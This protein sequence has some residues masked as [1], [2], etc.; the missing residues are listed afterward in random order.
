MAKIPTADSIQRVL[1]DGRSAIVREDVSNVGIGMMRIGDALGDAASTVNQFNE[2][3]KRKTDEY[4]LEK[5]R[6]NFAIARSKLDQAASED[7]D[8]RSIEE[9]YYQGNLDALNSAASGIDDPELRNA[10]MLEGERGVEDNR[11]R[12]REYAKA[13][14]HDAERASIESQ[15]KEL[16]ELGLTGEN[17]NEAASQVDRLVSAAVANEHF[18]EQEA[19]KVGYAFRT[20]LAEA[21]LKMIADPEERLRVLKEP[22]VSNLPTDVRAALEREARDEVLNGRAQRMVDEFIRKDMTIDQVLEK[23]REI[24]NPDLRKAVES[25]YD[26]EQARAE[27]NRRLEQDV[28]Y[29]E[30]SLIIENDGTYEEIPTAV[31]SALTPAMRDNLRN[32]QLNRVKPRERSDRGAYLRLL[33]LTRKAEFSNNWDAVRQEWNEL[34]GQLNDSDFKTFSKVFADGVM[35]EEFKPLFTAQNTLTRLMKDMPEEEQ[36]RLR[37]ELTSWYNGVYANTQKVPSDAI[38]TEHLDN[39][40]TE[41]H[42][43]DWPLYTAPR[44]IYQMD[45]EQATNALAIAQAQS[46]ESA[47]LIKEI[48]EAMGKR[49]TAKDVLSRFNLIKTRRE[50]SANA[51]Q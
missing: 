4:Q 26:Y 37:D 46:E 51:A 30:A 24:S 47:Q 5:A 23:T 45:E 33:E 3:T 32:I 21:R 25:R 28:L 9:R 41:Y 38:V 17:F 49:A 1:P 27:S 19:E 34:S 29:N 11:S 35:P 6:T 44:A 13:K 8:Y 36:A 14:W 43:K 2:E 12:S 39:M 22:W 48:T 15:I 16:R 18:T 20:N 42:T 10:F 40:V 31:L 50:A 7:G